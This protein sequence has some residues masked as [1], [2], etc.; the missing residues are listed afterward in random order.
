MYI[1]TTNDNTIFAYADDL[2]ITVKGRRL[3]DIEGKL[4][5]ALNITFYITLHKEFSKTQLYQNSNEC[6]PIVNKCIIQ[7][8]QVHSMKLFIFRHRRWLE[9]RLMDLPEY[10][11]LVYQFKVIVSYL[12]LITLVFKKGALLKMSRIDSIIELVYS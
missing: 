10:V 7:L 4:K 1:Q 11:S 12:I 3:E 2:G 6:I 8:N 5:T 9:W